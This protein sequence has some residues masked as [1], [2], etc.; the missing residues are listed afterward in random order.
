MFAFLLFINKEDPL[1]DRKT[2]QSHEEYYDQD[3]DAAGLIIGVLVG[4]LIW[5]ITLG[6][7]IY[8][9]FFDKPTED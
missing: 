2:M 9:R 3:G 6:V 1:V 7:F 5:P 4:S 8:Y